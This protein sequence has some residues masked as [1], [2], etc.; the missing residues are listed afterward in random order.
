MKAVLEYTDHLISR[1][2]KQVFKILAEHNIEII[3]TKRSQFYDQIQVVIRVKDYDELNLLI[4]ELNQH[5]REG[6][7]L[8][9]VRHDSIFDRLRRETDEERI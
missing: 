3:K 1:D 5:C 2:G 9:K 7:K 4:F 6:V 8:I